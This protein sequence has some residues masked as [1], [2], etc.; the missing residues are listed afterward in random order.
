MFSNIN[1]SERAQ[2][3]VLLVAVDWGIIVRFDAFVTLRL[4]QFHSFLVFF[5]LL[6]HKYISPGLLRTQ[7]NHS[8]NYASRNGAYKGF[9]PFW[10]QKHFESSLYIRKFK[11]AFWKA[12]CNLPPAFSRLT[13]TINRL[14]RKFNVN[15][16]QKRAHHVSLL[17]RDLFNITRGNLVFF[18][19]KFVRCFTFP[20][21]P[22]L[23]HCHIEI[24]V[25]KKICRILGQT[26]KCFRP[27]SIL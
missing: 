10:L 13:E 6:R 4:T 11:E 7:C 27:V 25:S 14:K 8:C 3:F 2:L 23:F 9:F 21:L 17:D 26:S 5:L 20:F 15:F 12:C 22:F 1:I 19:R 16:R 24:A 18:A